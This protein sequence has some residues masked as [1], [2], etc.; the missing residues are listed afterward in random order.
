MDYVNS[1]MEPIVFIILIVLA[2]TRKELKGKAWLMTAIV[3]FLV[4]YLSAP[5]LYKLMD[6][7]DSSGQN[8]LSY[9]QISIYLHI[10]YFSACCFLVPYV[11][12]A[13]R[14]TSSGSIERTDSPAEKQEALTIGGW[15]VLPAI[16]LILSLIKAIGFFVMYLVLA[17]KIIPAGLDQHFHFAL[18]IDIGTFIFL[19]FASTRFFKK[20]ANTPT[21][22]IALLIYQLVGPGVCLVIFHLSEAGTLVSSITRDFA[23]ALILAIIW[24]PYFIFSKRV[25][26]TFV[27]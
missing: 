21:V 5:I 20:R 8:F 15:L 4:Y 7:A 25:K 18:S 12:L 1:A 22:M 11:I 19:I 17:E 24:I 26:E 3:L 23:F 13:G 2:S 10:V 27:N 16:M 9:S 14:K 6:L